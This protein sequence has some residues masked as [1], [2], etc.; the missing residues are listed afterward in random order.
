MS[1]LVFLSIKVLVEDQET[2][3]SKMLSVSSEHSLFWA[4]YLQREVVV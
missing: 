3:L 2:V 4:V 1:I